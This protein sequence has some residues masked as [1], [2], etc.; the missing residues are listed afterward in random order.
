MLRGPGFPAV[1]ALALL[2]G[3][4]VDEGDRLLAALGCRLRLS[5]GVL[6]LPGGLQ[7]PPGPACPAL[8]RPEV[9]PLLVDDALP[10]RMPP[11]F[12]ACGCWQCSRR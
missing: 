5:L 10:C 4:R 1:Q 9:E 3:G 12:Q 7:A 11:R 8:P 6:Q 2:Q